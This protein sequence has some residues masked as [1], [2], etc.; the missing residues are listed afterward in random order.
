MQVTTEN[1]IEPKSAKEFTKKVASLLMDDEINI[2]DVMVL[3]TKESTVEVNAKFTTTFYDLYE[4]SLKIAEIL[5]GKMTQ[6]M[7]D[8]LFR[9]ATL[10]CARVIAF[11]YL[12]NCE[13][14]KARQTQPSA[15]ATDKP[16]LSQLEVEVKSKMKDG[17]TWN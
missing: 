10:D 5:Q 16:N 15:S 4:K 14:S 8:E 2:K 12:A 3:F 11:N 1:K 6:E 17:L 13:I 7:A 9:V